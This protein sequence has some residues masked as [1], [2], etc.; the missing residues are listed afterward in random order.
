MK[1]AEEKQTAYQVYCAVTG[2]VYKVLNAIC[3][4][5]LGIELFAV[6]VMVVGR[7][8]FNSVPLWTD[9]LSLMALV[10]M[11]MV[12]I[13]LALYD[14]S[15]MRVELLDRFLPPKA[16]TALKYLSNV[17]VAVFSFFMITEGYALFDLTKEVRLSGF[18]VSKGLMYLPLLLCGIGSIYMC[19]FCIVRRIKEG[20]ERDDE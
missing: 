20:R 18:R 13:T 14:E 1:S 4:A 7:F 11:S 3:V 6:I 8:V 5:C 2:W 15:H 10:W 16:V 17:V 9:Q 19:V 12:S